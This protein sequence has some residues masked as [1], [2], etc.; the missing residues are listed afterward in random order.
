MISASL[1]LKPKNDA[2]NKSMSSRTPP[3]FTKFGSLKA[4]GSTPAAA[5]SSFEKNEMHST[6]SRKFPQNVSRFLAF[7]K[8]P[9]MPT[10]AMLS[11][12]DGGSGLFISRYPPHHPSL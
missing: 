1:A 5:R 12:L 2:S 7:G 10:M 4:P 3:A 9:L 8:R 6:P 11:E